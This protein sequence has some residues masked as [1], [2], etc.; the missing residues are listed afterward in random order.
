MKILSRVLSAA[1]LTAKNPCNHSPK[2]TRRLLITVTFQNNSMF[3]GR[4]FFEANLKKVQYARGG[5][6]VLK[7]KDH[8]FDTVRL[9]CST[10]EFKK[11]GKGGGSFEV[12][13]KIDGEHFWN[14]TAVLCEVDRSVESHTS[15]FVTACT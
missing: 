8:P 6:V 9:R 5:I 13:G 7:I 15:T 4:E 10:K 2:S 12:W 3:G 11:R 1:G 14:A